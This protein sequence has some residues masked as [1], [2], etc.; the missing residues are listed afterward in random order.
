VDD[1]VRT[2]IDS[3]EEMYEILKNCYAIDDD[4]DEGRNQLL[5]IVQIGK[6]WEYN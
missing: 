4:M 5:Y 1:K 6:A 3:W 2:P